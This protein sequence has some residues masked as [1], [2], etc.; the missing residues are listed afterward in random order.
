MNQMWPEP[1]MNQAVGFAAARERH[2]SDE[3]VPYQSNLRAIGADLD[4]QHR[5]QA[6]VMEVPSGFD[7]SSCARGSTGDR[8]QKLV[9]HAELRE[10]KGG[11][12]HRKMRILRHGAKEEF[13]YED[14]FRAIGY[15]LEKSRAYVMLLDELDDGFL[16]TYQHYSRDA[17]YLLRKGRVVLGHTDQVLLLR[18]AVARRSP[19]GTRARR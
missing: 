13:S 14:L 3:P 18:S 4:A 6:R 9:T 1:A 2:L 16:L 10:H 5:D 19:H 17:G 15:L 12:Y 11:S 8:E 7:V